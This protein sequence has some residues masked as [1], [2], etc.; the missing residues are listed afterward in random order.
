MRLIIATALA[1]LCLL[2]CCFCGLMLDGE[3]QTGGVTI[4]LGIIFV[5][6]P[7]LSGEMS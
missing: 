6:V 4:S 7:W 3:T 2:A 1:F 5:V